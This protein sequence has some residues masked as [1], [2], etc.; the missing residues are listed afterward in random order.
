MYVYGYKISIFHKI[1]VAFF[2]LDSKLSEP[3]NSLFTYAMLS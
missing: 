1:H 3:I 2:E